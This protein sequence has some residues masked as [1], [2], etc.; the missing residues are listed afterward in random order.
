[1]KFKLLLSV[2]GIKLRLNA[3]FSAAF[4]KR[5]RKKDL[6]LVI[7]TDVEKEAR[8]YCI[9]GGKVRSRSGRDRSAETELVWC[10]CDTAVRIMLS[11][12]EL[13]GFSAIGRGQLRILG[14]FEQAF[15][16]LELAG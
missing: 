9:K 15:W 16:F 11:K 7:R 2:L 6:V 5:L 12:N 4:R 13:D 8:T 10:D 1:M 14:N 3:I